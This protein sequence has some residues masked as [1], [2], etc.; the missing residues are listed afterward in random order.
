MSEH[1]QNRGKRDR[2]DHVLPQGYLNGFTNPSNQGKV[3]VFD[4]QRQRWFDT[5]TAGVGA[6]KGFYDYPQGTEPDQTANKAFAGLE[7]VTQSSA[8]SN[9]AVLSISRAAEFLRREIPRYL[10]ECFVS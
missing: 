3:C 2:W 8:F 7:R 6:I 1:P 9:S 5:G 10:L 4:R